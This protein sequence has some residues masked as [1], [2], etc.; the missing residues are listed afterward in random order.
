VSD[1]N[2]CINN[3]A[4]TITV[5]PVLSINT[6][7][8]TSI[9]AGTGTQL[10]SSGGIIYSWTPAGGLNNSNVANPTAN[11]VNTTTYTV[12]VTD[13]NG[14]SGNGTVN[15]IVNPL[16]T[17]TTSAGASICAGLNA[18]MSASGGITY[19]WIPST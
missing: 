17:V 7:P 3:A 5:N 1:T 9:C 14:C 2:G 18:Q 8:S 19:S 12:H 11:P 10:T 13:A 6:C 4:T 15:I 16:P